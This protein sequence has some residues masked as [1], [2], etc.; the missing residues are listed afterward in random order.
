MGIWTYAIISIFMIKAIKRLQY[1][2]DVLLYSMISFI[3]AAISEVPFILV[4]LYCKNLHGKTEN[5]E[6]C[7]Q[8]CSK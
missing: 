3:C 6:N 4:A 2:N 7:I 5:P 8:Q 1:G